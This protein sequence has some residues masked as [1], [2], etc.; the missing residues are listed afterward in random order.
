[1]EPFH[2]CGLADWWVWDVKDE[3][4]WTTVQWVLTH[5]YAFPSTQTK[6]L[7][8]Q[9]FEFQTTKLLTG[10]PR[11]RR[12]SNLSH[13]Q[14]EFTILNRPSPSCSKMQ[15]LKKKTSLLHKAHN[16]LFGPI[17]QSLR[18]GFSFNCFSWNELL[19]VGLNA[20][21]VQKEQESEQQKERTDT[22][23]STPGQS[24][25][26]PASCQQLPPLLRIT[27]PQEITQGR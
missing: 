14:H 19:Q 13:F 5:T 10:N 22:G 21:L 1:M 4:M 26:S 16:T 3:E 17:H 24:A 12:K 18:C 11:I 9:M 8:L 25:H 15:L 2:P 27:S 6:E 20:K 23:L 7:T